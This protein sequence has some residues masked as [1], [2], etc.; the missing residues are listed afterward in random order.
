MKAGARGAMEWGGGRLDASQRRFLSELPLT[1][2]EG[3][4]LYVHSEASSPGKWRYVQ[5]TADAARSIVAATAQITFCGHVHR[6]ALYS[7]SAAAKMTSFVPT[8][9]V[10]VQLLSGRKWLAELA[11]VGHTLHANPAASFPPLVSVTRE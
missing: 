2:E 8:S 9:G 6:P 11:S 7:M 3:D 1:A 10:S 5:E 4:R